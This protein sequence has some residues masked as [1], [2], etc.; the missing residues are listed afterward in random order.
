M[1]LKRN[2]NYVVKYTDYFW[3]EID[4]IS[5]YI[6][7]N[8]YESTLLKFKNKLF[9]CFDNMEMF[10]KMYMKYSKKKRYRRVFIYNYILFYKIN[11]K[12]KTIEIVH[13]YYARK[14]SFNLN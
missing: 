8:Y 11:Y 6:L 7:D 1:Q 4:E 3:K 12:D 10:P 13:I 9:M 5:K 2:K 14:G